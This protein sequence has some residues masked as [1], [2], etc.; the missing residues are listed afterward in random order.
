[1]YS[2]M[3]GNRSSS[4]YQIDHIVPLWAGGADTAANKQVLTWNTHNLKTNI[5]AIPLTLLANKV[6]NVN[7][8]R[9]LAMNWQDL[10]AT[11]VPQ[12]DDTGMVPLQQAMDVYK[13][14]QK[15]KADGVAIK[16]NKPL[17]GWNFIK[18]AFSPKNVAEA[19]KNVGDNLVPDFIPGNKALEGLVQGFASGLTGGWIPGVAA[20]ASLTEK[21][22]GI[23]GG[24][25]GMLLP[26][27]WMAKG[28]GVTG[29][30]AVG[31]A[32]KT[33]A[34]NGF[35]FSRAGILNAAKNISGTAASAVRATSPSYL[36]TIAANNAVK[37][38]AAFTA[39]GQLSREGAL[40]KAA[41]SMGIAQEGIA[42]PMERLFEDITY[43]IVTGIAR[44]T[45]RGTAMVMGT[46][47]L[48]G[49][50]T[51]GLR[52]RPEDDWLSEALITSGVMGALH[53]AAAA[54]MTSFVNPRKTAL[55]P[56]ESKAPATIP[57]ESPIFNIVQQNDDMATSMASDI[58]DT[59]TG[60]GRTPRGKNGEILPQGA[61]EYNIGVIEGIVKDAEEAAWRLATNGKTT[62][63]AVEDLVN[64]TMP[65]L[66]AE[67]ARI[68]AAGM[69]LARRGMDME[70]RLDAQ[71]GDVLSLFS[72]FK[73]SGKLG[74]PGNMYESPNASQA[75]QAM[76]GSLLTKSLKNAD[77]Q[78]APS[79][80]FPVG[81]HR[82]T[83]VA[84]TVNSLNAENVRVYLTLLDKPKDGWTASPT[85]VVADRSE[86]AP[87]WR[88]MSKIMEEEIAKGKKSD[89]TAVPFRHPENS[90]EVY[91]VLYNNVTGEKKLVSLGMLSRESR[92]GSTDGSS[93]PMS[94]N[95][96][97]EVKDY[98][99]SGGQTGF[100]PLNPLFN[101]DS[102]MQSMRDNG[103]QFLFVNVDRANSGLR[104]VRSKE[105]YL[106]ITINDAN[107]N[108]S[109]ERARSLKSVAR[110][111]ETPSAVGQV[112]R[113]V[114]K[115]QSN[116]KIIST[117]KQSRDRVLD[118]ADEVMFKA[119]EKN[120]GIA[121]DGLHY[122]YTFLNDV[123]S[124]FSEPTNISDLQKALDRI[125]VKVTA[126]EATALMMQ[127]D[128]MTVRDTV[129]FLI[130]KANE[131]MAK[132]SL[133]GALEGTV[134]PVMK[135]EAFRGWATKGGFN[136]W[137]LKL[138][139]GLP[140]RR[141]SPTAYRKAEIVPN[142]APARTTEAPTPARETPE[143]QTTAP[144]E[145]PKSIP[146]DTPE[147]MPIPQKNSIASRISS[148][149]ITSPAHKAAASAMDDMVLRA[150]NIID[151][152]VVPD[153]RTAYAKRL[154]QI[155]RS[156]SPGG[157]TVS[158]GITK[159]FTPKE[160]SSMK[161]RVQD[162][163][164]IDAEDRVAGSF[165]LDEE[166][167]FRGLTMGEEGGQEAMKHYLMAEVSQA[168]GNMVGR[169]RHLSMIDETLVKPLAQR[170]S[171]AGVGG[172]AK[173]VVGTIEAARERTAAR[174]A[175]TPTKAEAAKSPAP[176]KTKEELNAIG[177]R[178][179]ADGRKVMEMIRDGEEAPAG[180]YLHGFSVAM[181][182]GL[183]APGMKGL[184]DF[185]GKWFLRNL[186]STVDPSSYNVKTRYSNLYSTMDSANTLKE[187]T[188]PSKYLKAFG[189]GDKGEKARAEG[190]RAEQIA[191]A[192]EMI[193]AGEL[194][195]E[196]IDEVRSGNLKVIKDVYGGEN[197]I[198]VT[199]GESVGALFPAL[200][201]IDSPTAKHG[202][203]D[204]RSFLQ[205]IIAVHNANVSSGRKFGSTGKKY[206]GITEWRRGRTNQ[207]IEAE[208]TRFF[209]NIIDTLPET[210]DPTA[211]TGPRMKAWSPE[212]VKLYGRLK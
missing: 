55:I 27:G 140:A 149:A 113:A 194:P 10:D 90:G 31:T 60:T 52:D 192:E 80:E 163:L 78:G 196:V 159:N 169:D 182:K 130:D 47:L 84:S 82:V 209:D 86:F 74:A 125:G 43:G 198:P 201:S 203:I 89:S 207:D 156:V 122:T 121:E 98:I 204:A 76:D 51:Q 115:K 42:R 26:V 193:A 152:M 212:S 188:Q 67:I 148:K 205:Q 8:A 83:G 135:S 200:N 139:G 151:N 17:T 44:P 71:V 157:K 49:A 36:K 211:Y 168:M 97:P 30:V 170:L 172:D 56:Y 178:H 22:F 197:A 153:T 34:K 184:G 61:T 116:E 206:I 69:Q 53:L 62:N 147:V 39:Y 138:L 14:W 160:V 117:L 124:A 21:G 7:E 4:L 202:V 158:K 50:M 179:E 104:A 24:I 142:E 191:A 100:P 35:S 45:L 15:E 75:L 154:G 87:I 12:R 81:T 57:G 103:L 180:S 11:D 161:K 132:K 141:P 92:I 112:A 109:I 3:L 59:W 150:T 20:D 2:T 173:S 120:G 114:K 25:A 119:F 63:R 164:Y 136:F 79:G 129:H 38:E 13:T 183:Q 85:L 187:Y 186:G 177:N 96:Q 40:G 123:R 128:E 6:I 111:D 131:G 99:A 28:M 210:Y 105:P 126:D 127:R 64:M 208:T 18:D 137:D 5:Q 189:E 165:N 66:Q 181:K 155:I 107:W 102:I 176:K 48:L 95:A 88:K 166:I 72:K 110:V 144:I 133:V 174:E 77:Y 162:R 91:A 195:P 167:A 175:L 23:V 93:H 54:H 16:D 46:P 73:E 68:R 134:L 41:E 145:A 190:D 19:S 94:F 108:T 143:L 58:L 32:A 29:K 9:L 70:A 65:E 118:P 1:M 106:H 146:L 101:K 37:Y 33:A 171:A 185:G 199:K